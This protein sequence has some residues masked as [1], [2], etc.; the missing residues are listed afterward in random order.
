[1]K[2]GAGAG[3]LKRLGVLGLA[4][5]LAVVGCTGEGDERYRPGA[6]TSGDTYFP[7]L[8][9]GGYDVT[10]YRLF[11]DYDEDE[12]VGQA[13][14][15]ATATQGLSRF[16]LDL[17]GLSVG[18]VILNGRPTT[19][20][21][22]R[23]K[24]FVDAESGLDEGK[25]FV[26]EVHY[27]GVP[28][29]ASHPTLGLGGFF[30]A[31][32]PD[33]VAM[34]QPFSAS[35]WF[36]VNDHPSDKATFE[37]RVAV[38]EGL[39]AVSNGALVDEWTEDG[40]TVRVWSER[41]PMASYLAVLATGNLRIQKSTHRGKPMVTA[42]HADVPK[43][44][45]AQ[46][47]VARTGEVADYFATLFGPYPFDSYGGIVVSD[48]RIKYALE[49]QSRPVYDASSFR[50]GENL[51]VVAH[52]VAHQWFGN[53]VSLTRWSDMWLNE[54]FAT[55]AE[56]LWAEHDGGP[57]VQQAFARRYAVTDWSKPA[58]DPGPD[59]LFSDAVYQRGALAV[60]ALRR[61][62]GDDAFFTTLRTFLTEHRNGNATT[63]D[64]VALA[65]R[66][67]GRQ[68]DALFDAWLTGKTA[69]K[70]P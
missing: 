35:T 25:D 8:G 68:L 32:G 40:W 44:G 43:G 27:G 66:V 53:S 24:L 30:D 21:Q 41:F 20:R 36:P 6:A 59:N 1:M 47:S 11:I 23:A 48:D 69:P 64:F 62:V 46:R 3:R 2:H 51:A 52:E 31:E 67:S 9:N 60:H 10:S 34:G 7:D 28:T 42:Y 37:I 5:T 17:A 12:L 14:I 49:T 65:E 22:N 45:P 56:W 63:E 70:V 29:T 15:I 58:L 55:Y 38:P 61:T 19:F 26:V 13:S 33:A 39:A 57:T 4:L 54:G 16:S 18:T 50:S